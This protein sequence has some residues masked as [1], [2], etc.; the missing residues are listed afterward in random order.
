MDK[1]LDLEYANIDLDRTERTGMQEV[2]YCAGKT[3]EQIA[4]IVGAMVERGLYNILLTRIS[5]EKAQCLQAETF[6][7]PCIDL[8]PID[9]LLII[10]NSQFYN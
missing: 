9:N 8:F 6:P 5:E 10:Y 1:N 4:G 2:I 3:A 7:Y